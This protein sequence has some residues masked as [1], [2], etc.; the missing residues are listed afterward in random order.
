MHICNSFHVRI[1]LSDFAFKVIKLLVKL[2]CE[3][4]LSFFKNYLKGI[5]SCLLQGH[6][7]T[8][9][10]RCPRSTFLVATTSCWG[11]WTVWRTW[12]SNQTTPRPW[13][14]SE[15][16]PVQ[17]AEQE[18]KSS[19]LQRV[20]SAT[21]STRVSYLTIAS[22]TN[23]LL[24]SYYEVH[25]LLNIS[26]ELRSTFT[27]CQNIGFLFLDPGHKEN[28]RAL[29]TEVKRQNETRGGRWIE[30]PMHP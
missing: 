28:L 26:N 14:P 13:S 6:N 12:P 22:V 4:V 29:L 16:P 1:P 11:S 5:F 19:W 23:N 25:L 15:N 30:S 9:S 2:S 21:T 24:H 17:S 27:N 3:F 10:P 20:P 8:S 18:T 7:I